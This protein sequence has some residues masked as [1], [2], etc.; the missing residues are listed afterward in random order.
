VDQNGRSREFCLVRC[1][2]LWLQRQ[3]GRAPHRAG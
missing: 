2:G 3:P 1:V